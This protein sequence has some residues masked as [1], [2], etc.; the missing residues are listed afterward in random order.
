MGLWCW[1]WRWLYPLLAASYSDS[2][3]LYRVVSHG[4]RCAAPRVPCASARARSL[5][6][7]WMLRAGSVSQPRI[8]KTRELFCAYGDPASYPDDT[9]DTRV[10]RECPPCCNRIVTHLHAAVERRHQRPQ[11]GPEHAQA[12]LRELCCGG[13]ACEGRCATLRESSPTRDITT[14]AENQP[15]WRVTLLL[16]IPGTITR[17]YPEY[18]DPQRGGFLTVFC[19]IFISHFAS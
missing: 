11:R 7:L 5:L 9:R 17:G 8:Q 16:R 14:T 15:Q 13:V 4:G 3:L 12:P 1:R 10:C 6:R 18:T 19:D 2:D